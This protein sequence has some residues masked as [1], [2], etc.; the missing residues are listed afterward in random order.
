MGDQR[1]LVKQMRCGD[2]KAKTGKGAGKQYNSARIK[3]NV[4]EDVS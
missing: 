3:D 1:I 2:T 4:R